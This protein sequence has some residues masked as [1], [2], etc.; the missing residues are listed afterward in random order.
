MLKRTALL[1]L[2]LL[3]LSWPAQAQIYPN[4][5]PNTFL[6][7]LGAG[8]P[9]P[10]Q[11]ISFA[12]FPFGQI[13]PLTITP[14][15]GT[16][17]QGLVVN[18]TGPASV[19][20]SGPTIFNNI[21]ATYTGGSVAA[22]S[23]S[24]GLF[25]D[26]SDAFQVLYSVGSNNMAGFYLAGQY[27]INV[28]SA[29]TTNAT[30]IIALA[31]TVNSNVALNSGTAIE[32]LNAGT[33]IG[34]SGSVGFALGAEF[35]VGVAGT[36]ANRYGIQIQTAQVGGVN[37]TQGT[38]ADAAII[39]LSNN[40]GGAGGFK[41][42]V[43]LSNAGNPPSGSPLDSAAN[44][45]SATNAQTIA[46]VF[47]LPNETVTGN[48]LN[49]PN[50]AIAG[51]GAAVFGA[52]ASSLPS[53]GIVAVTGPSFGELSIISNANGASG[54][55][56]F[57]AAD[58]AN[59][60]LMAAGVFEA[61]NTLTRFGQTAGDWAFLLSNNGTSNHNNGLMAGTFVA[62]PFLFGTNN[63]LAG[64]INS[65]Q[66]WSIGSSLSNTPASGVLFTISGQSGVTSQS[67]LVPSSIAQIVAANGT[68]NTLEFDAFANGASISNIVSG[69]V[70]GGTA[71]SISATPNS[72]FVWAL[73]GYG[74]DGSVAAL[75]ASVNM[76]TTELW[77]SGHHGMAVLIGAT[78]G[79]STS[80]ATVATF[81]AGVQIGAPTGGDEG[82]GTINVATAYY[83]NGTIGVTCSGSPTA[84]FAS[85]KGIV[86]H[87]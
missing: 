64:F 32:G 15:T 34:P 40:T 20:S 58:S 87:C 51:S 22:G 10:P 37:S 43:L 61:S 67:V 9:G 39:L 78:P 48:I 30:D 47:N 19:T 52:G 18:Q 38:S 26:R 42:L 60:T 27:A 8:I 68:N 16:L 70:Y 7:R 69:I 3:A 11:A 29:A 24:F 31:G 21:S 74:Y 59:G 86:T 50:V 12:N 28:T 44:L 14:P 23:D 79:S 57:Q 1:A 53:T 17:T 75:A 55:D 25:N 84:S 71:G 4:I 5:P 81:Q 80:K 56:Y 83:S 66:Q 46:N 62:K 33:A 72:T 35:D 73:G 41:N 6:G 49:F 13:A 2:A 45:F 77:S 82:A 54:L 63:T 85:V 76:E 36:V 65:S